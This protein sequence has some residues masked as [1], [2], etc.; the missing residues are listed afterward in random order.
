MRLVS[1][2]VLSMVLAVRALA[3]QEVAPPRRLSVEDAVARA[4]AASHRLAEM[5]AREGAATAAAA[6]RQAARRPTLSAELGYTRTNHVDEF[7]IRTPDGAFRLLYPDVPDNYRSRID[8]RW[9]IYTGGRL[10]A[11]ERAARAEAAATGRDL[12]AARADLRLEVTRSFWAVVTARDAVRVVEQG[13]A[14]V[15]AQ[16]RDV[17]AL[18][19][20]GFV[21]PND[22]LTVEAQRSRQRTLLIE[23]RNQA[24]LAEATLERLIDAPDGLALELD[25]ALDDP[26]GLEAQPVDS[27]VRD[28]RGARPERAAL[29]YRLAAASE[30]QEAAAAGARP[31]LALTSGV[32][33]ARPNPRHFPREDTWQE[34]WDV[35]VA[36]TWSFWDGGRVRAERAEAAQQSIAARARLEEFD[37]LLRLDI[38]QHLLDLEAALAQIATAGD[39]VRAATEAR[40]VVQERFSAG[41]ATSTEL[42]DAEE[43]LLRADLDRTRALA[44]AR[45]ARARLDRATGR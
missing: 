33:Y 45:L 27:L 2:F 34:S 13:L 15:E 21:P 14:R 30:R 8:L 42:L 3:A 32:D 1:I 43:V 23:A 12:E 7:G 17:Q 29:E 41:V 28:A 38:R 39:A 10:E 37:S 26:V 6:G 24:A 40:R 11:L 5:R 44:T 18:F 20:T 25:A 4:T 16:L 36:F 35:G 31:T 19:E 22:V 9:P